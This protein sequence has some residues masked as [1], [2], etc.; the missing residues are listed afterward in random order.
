MSRV[1]VIM[2]IG[3]LERVKTKKDLFFTATNTIAWWRSEEERDQTT[4]YRS[5]S[6]TLTE[7]TG[8]KVCNDFLAFRETEQSFSIQKRKKSVKTDFMPQIT[9]G[10][11]KL[12]TLCTSWNC[13]LKLLRVK[14]TPLYSVELDP[15]L[16]TGLMLYTLDYLNLLTRSFFVFLYKTNK[17]EKVVP[18]S[19]RKCYIL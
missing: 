18:L 12:G 19:L 1:W 7:Y 15:T 2:A 17:S 16:Y 4:V 11:S 10:L 13:S 14:S 3:S 9:I 8:F 5:V 6:L